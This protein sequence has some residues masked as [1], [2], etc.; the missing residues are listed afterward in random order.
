MDMVKDRQLGVPTYQLLLSA[1]ERCDSAHVRLLLEHGALSSGYGFRASLAAVQKGSVKSLRVLLEHEAAGGYASQG[2]IACMHLILS[3]S[4]GAITPWFLNVALAI[5]AQR[6]SWQAV[7]LLVSAGA[8]AAA[9]GNIA[10]QSMVSATWGWEYMAGVHRRLLYWIKDLSSNA[11][12]STSQVSRSRISIEAEY[13][14][15]VRRS[16]SVTAIDDQEV[17]QCFKAAVDLSLLGTVSLAKAAVTWAAVL[18]VKAR[19]TCHVY[20]RKAALLGVASSEGNHKLLALLQ[21]RQVMSASWRRCA[22]ILYSGFMPALQVRA[23][24]S[25]RA[26]WWHADTGASPTCWQ[27]GLRLLAWSFSRVLCFAV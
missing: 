16:D 15:S 17:E 23:G 24:S 3:L 6:G 18:L 5:A 7:E 20:L 11:S 13:L 26:R 1:I 19:T 25:D 9:A 2:H 12:T 14:R 27:S 8:G 10:L 4:R 21:G 22:C